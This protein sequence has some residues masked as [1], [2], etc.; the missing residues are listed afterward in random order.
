MTLE[1]RP[2]NLEGRG[3]ITIRQL[4]RNAL[5][6]RPDRLLL[7]E[8]RGG[9]ALDLLQALEH[10]AR[11]LAFDYP[12]EQPARCPV[13][14]RDTDADGRSRPAPAGSPGTSRVGSTACGPAAAASR[15]SP[16]GDPSFGDHGHRRAAAL[17]PAIC[18]TGT[19]FGNTGSGMNPFLIAALSALSARQDSSTPSR[20]PA[21]RSAMQVAFGT[22]DGRVHGSHRRAETAERR[23]KGPAA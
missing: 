15:R 21:R 4:V 22:D 20:R 16:P 6:M 2:P 3:E 23:R 1:S 7:G 12:R 5:R 13:S 9:E 18:F 10:R 11:R 17:P 8:V 14:L 19:R